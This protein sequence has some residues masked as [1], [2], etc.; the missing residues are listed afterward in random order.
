M[1]GLLG[2]AEL[3]MD[4]AAPRSHPAKRLYGQPNQMPGYSNGIF[5]DAPAQ[6]RA[7]AAPVAAPYADDAQQN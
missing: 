4:Q 1:M 5:D 3:A 6:V 2:P 7:P